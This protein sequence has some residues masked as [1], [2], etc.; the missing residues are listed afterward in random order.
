MC[1]VASKLFF[2]YM[3]LVLTIGLAVNTGAEGNVDVK[4]RRI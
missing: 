3:V 4:G 2:L 1:R